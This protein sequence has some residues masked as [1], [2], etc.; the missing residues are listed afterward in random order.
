MG[1]RPLT[2][3]EV[4]AASAGWQGETPL[5]YY[6]LREADVRAGGNRLGPAGARIVGEVVIGLLDLDP[7]SV[8]HAPKRVATSR[9]PARIAQPFALSVQR[10]AFCSSHRA[11]GT[12]GALPMGARLRLKASKDLTRYPPQ[13]QSMF[14]AMQTYGLIVADNGSDMYVTGV[15]DARW[16]NW[17]QPCIRKPD[18]SKLNASNSA[19]DEQCF[20]SSVHRPAFCSS[21]SA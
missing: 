9:H 18:C 13:I 19:G 8:R 11:G 20:G 2:R 12:A 15:M 6:V 1:E 14:R 7:T 21:S 10:P 4:G 16:N 5:W 17:N 3:E